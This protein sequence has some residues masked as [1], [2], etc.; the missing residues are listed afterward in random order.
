MSLSQLTL[1]NCRAI[2]TLHALSFDVPWSEH[3]FETFLRLPTYRAFGWMSEE[4]E[5]QGLLLVS[6]IEPE[7]EISTICVNPSLRRQGIAENLI[8]GALEYFDIFHSCFLEV[9]EFNFGAIALYSKLGFKVTGRRENYYNT[10]GG[11][12]RDALLMK[13]ALDELV[14]GH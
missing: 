13:L 10:A 9:S 1:Q 14:K 11:R 3:D 7:L 8:I 12:D 2:A 5:L 4:H 6:V